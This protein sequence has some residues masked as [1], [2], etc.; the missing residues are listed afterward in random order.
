MYLWLWYDVPIYPPVQGLERYR[1]GIISVAIW[2]E[3][4]MLYI[5]SELVVRCYGPEDIQAGIRD[6]VSFFAKESSAEESERC[7]L[8]IPIRQ[9][10]REERTVIEMKKDVRKQFWRKAEE[11]CRHDSMSRRKDFDRCLRGTVDETESAS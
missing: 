2:I 7:L 10:S 5:N 11:C 3:P 6:H 4:H 8:E 9:S 1:K